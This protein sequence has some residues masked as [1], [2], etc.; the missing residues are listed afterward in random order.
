MPTAPDTIHTFASK[1]A[2]AELS[3]TDCRDETTRRTVHGRAYYA[4]FHA[5]VAAARAAKRF[6]KFEP[7]HGGF[8]T[9]LAGGDEKLVEVGG[10]LSTLL[11]RRKDADYKLALSIDVN[12]LGLLLGV[13]KGIIDDAPA[14]EAAFKRDARPLPDR[15][16]RSAP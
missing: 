3:A 1:L 5:V 11:E 8:I 2:N 10:M 16:G 4:A 9:H 13:S 12:L 15:H 6:P 7:E 14:I